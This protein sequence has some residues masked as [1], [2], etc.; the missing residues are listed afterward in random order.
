MKLEHNVQLGVK[1]SDGRLLQ[2]TLAFAQEAERLGKIMTEAAEA[3]KDFKKALDELENTVVELEITETTQ[4][5][6]FWVRV[7]RFFKSIFVL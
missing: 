3:L 6:S 7:K 1:I 2:N 5:V 4:S